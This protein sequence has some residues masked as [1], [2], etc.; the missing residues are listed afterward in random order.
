MANKVTLTIKKKNDQG[1]ITTEEEKFTIDRM[2]FL[3]IINLTKEIKAIAENIKNNRDLVSVLESLYGDKEKAPEGMDPEE[4][5]ALK[6]QRM[7]SGIAGGFTDILEHFPEHAIN[8]LSIASGIPEEILVSAYAEEVLDVFDA[9]IEENDIVKLWKR[10][11]K[12]FFNV[13]D[14]WTGLVKKATAE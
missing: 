13:K 10:V 12:S 4:L 2:T 11:Q 14:H 1:K 7:L 3:Q 5:E 6:D 8:I 9:I